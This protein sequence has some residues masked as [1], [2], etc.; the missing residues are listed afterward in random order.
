MQEPKTRPSSFDAPMGHTLLPVDATLIVLRQP[1]CQA[2][3][4]LH[5]PCGESM[6]LLHS[7][8]RRPV[9]N[10]IAV[11]NIAQPGSPHCQLCGPRTPAQPLGSTPTI[12]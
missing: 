9:L 5:S 7:L 6:Q 12:P 10:C 3:W 4:V 11:H 2:P 8:F 1:S